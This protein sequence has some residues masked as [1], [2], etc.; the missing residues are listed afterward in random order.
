MKRVCKSCQSEAELGPPSLDLGF[1]A[2]L[3]KDSAATF[4]PHVY[5]VFS[6]SPYVIISVLSI[7]DEK[8]SMPK[9]GRK[10][11]TQ[12]WCGW[13]GEESPQ[14]GGQTMETVSFESQE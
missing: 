13:E 5:A 9:F 10:T 8:A 1:R 3:M 2:I 14:Q 12:N 11:D 6:E 4:R 7:S